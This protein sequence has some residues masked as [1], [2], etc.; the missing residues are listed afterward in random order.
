MRKLR[1]LH[2]IDKL[3]MDGVN[4][5]SCAVLLTE[6][7]HTL[8]SDRYDMDVCSLRQ[9]DPAGAYLEEKGISVDYLGYGKISPGNINGIARLI[10]DKVYDIVHLH[11]YSAANFGRIAAKRMGIPNVVHEHAVLKVLPHQ[12]IA[13]KI[14]S[15]VTD[16]AIAVSENVKEFMIKYRSIPSEKIRTIGNGI[17]LEKF[18]I[19]DSEF[20]RSKKSELGV[21]KNTRIVGSVTRFREEKGNEYLIRAVPS[22]LKAHEDTVFLLVGDGPQ[23]QVLEGLV[24]ELDIAD[25]VR[26]LG[27]RSD[28]SQLLSVFDVQV[29]PSLT[30]GFPLCLVEAMAAGN[31]TVATAVGGMKSIGRDGESLMLVPPADT[32][33]LAKKI[34]YLLSDS[35]HA[36]RLSKCAR[37]ES[38]RFSIEKCSSHIAQVYEDLTRGVS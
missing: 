36:N 17:R 9:P 7:C 8:D 29:I 21:S 14:L 25:K 24:R 3:S 13:D 31:P 6:W 28:V 4:P 19:Y 10:K 20:K 35:E 15:R 18:D 16:S 32:P 34:E 23:R 12:F 37:Q 33:A 26:F 11:G 38:R 1:I 27:F 5:S 2:V 30:E 22:V